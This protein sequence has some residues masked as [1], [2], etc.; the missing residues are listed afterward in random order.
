MNT[1][2]VSVIMSVYNG[3]RFLPEALESVAGQTF[4][5]FEF[6]VVNDGSTDDSP[7]IIRAFPDPRFRLIS[8][9]ENIGLTRS[10]NR[11]IALARG[12]YIARQDADDFS[13][14][15]RLEEQVKY[16]EN[17]RDVALLGTSVR[18]IDELTGETRD[19]TAAADPAPGLRR[20][21]QFYH[22]SVMFRKGVVAGLGGYNELFRYGQDYELWLRIAAQHRVANLGRVLYVF[23]LHRE[24]IR[25]ARVEAAMLYHFLAQRTAGGRSPGAGTDLTGGDISRLYDRLDASEKTLFHRAVGQVHARNGDLKTARREYARAWKSRPW[26]LR[27]AAGWLLTFSTRRLM[28]RFYRLNDFIRS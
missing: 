13:L 22:G 1:P 11:A 18:V 23:R 25:A 15:Q 2:L 19:I 8:N 4:K 16:L 27:S 14:P 28:L 26:D 9:P 24:S 5:D 6:L 3:A 12:S 10:L 17:H 21:N 20:Q 7:E